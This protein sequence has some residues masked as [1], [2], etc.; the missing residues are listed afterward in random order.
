MQVDAGIVKIR[1]LLTA[2]RPR[3]IADSRELAQAAQ[4]PLH[5]PGD[6]VPDRT[7]LI[8]RMMEEIAKLR[9]DI[10]GVDVQSPTAVNARD[11]TAKALLETH[12]ALAD[13]ADTSVADDQT[14][15]ITLLAKSVNH[16]KSAQATSTSAAQA[17]GIPWPLQ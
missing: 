7:P 5:A 2:A 10:R 15:A 12:Q 13:L 4:Q 16:L 11:L 8:S 14:E 3:L 9:A 17:L 1:A 6:A